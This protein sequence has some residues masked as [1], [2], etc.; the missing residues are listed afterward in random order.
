ME[1]G[2][3]W[4]WSEPHEV[5]GPCGEPSANGVS[6]GFCEDDETARR[7]AAEVGDDQTVLGELCDPRG[8]DGVDSARSDDPVVWRVCGISG[9]AIAD[10][11]GGMST[12]GSEVLPCRVS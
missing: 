2:V 10:D 3:T 8:W 9:G 5:T 11:H 12:G 1:Q 7:L 6:A 4:V